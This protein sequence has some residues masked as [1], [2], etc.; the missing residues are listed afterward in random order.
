[1]PKSHRP[2]LASAVSFVVALTLVVA[3]PAARADEGMWTFNHFPAER[4]AQEY[5]FTPSQEWLDHVRLS[6]VRFNSGGSG[7]FL[8][9]D[10]LSITN[11]H[12][13]ADCIHKLSSAE[14]DYMRDGF[15][16]HSLAE[17]QACPDLELNV[18]MSIE[19]VTARVQAAVAGAADAATAGDARRA[20]MAK[21]EKECEDATKLRCDVVTL[22]AGAEF[23]LYRY[24]KYTDVRL[25]F[26][27]AAQLA[28]FG[29]DPDN[30]NYPRYAVDFALFRVWEDGHPAPTPEHLTFKEAGPRE[31]E[32]TFVS[33]NP[34]RTGRLDSVAQLEWLR[35]V[36]YPSYLAHLDQIHG[37]LLAFAGRGAEQ[38]RIAQDDVLGVENSLKALSGYLSGLL[39]PD[40]MDKK[41]R[42]EGELRARVG[43]DPNLVAG[44]PWSD[45][46][47]AIATER[48][49]Y[50]RQAALRGLNS[51]SLPRIADT[52]VWLV[53]ERQKPNAERLREYRETAIPRVLR[54]LYSEAPIY[55]EYEEFRLA[56]ALR[57]FRFQFGLVH[58]LVV[59]VFG[60]RTP[61]QLAHE[62]I[63]GTHLA[64][65]AARKALVEGGS[66]AV[67]AS[68][69]PLIRLARAL[70]PEGRKLRKIEDDE[71]DAVEERAGS[72]IADAYFAVH[73]KDT[74]P[75]A[76]FTLR[77]T[78]GRVTGYEE[79]GHAVSWHTD[80]AGYF[81]RSAQHGGAEPYELPPA[82]V[83]AKDRLDLSDPVD[84]VSTHD[85]IGGNSG[86]P[87]IDREGNF[88]GII[89]DG[90][91]YGLPNN[92][93]YT[94]KQA[95]SIS[96]DAKAILDALT[97][98]YP[99]A[100]YLADELKAGKRGG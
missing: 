96:V 100:S 3:T 95:R 28:Y 26:S 36:A 6:S 41:R 16:A 32:V 91:L 10:G 4:F 51:I 62:L 33:G 31:G 27:P 8:S 1:M 49:I 77:L 17:E 45:I 35:D 15:I 30:F 48:T 65:V 7:S 80:F 60:D 93:V 47:R 63:A 57:A 21:I 55:P 72:R 23:D 78:Y 71:V 73:G 70:E 61:E 44:D 76:T 29:G 75:D 58:P 64:D 59:Q 5:G 81:A 38:A 68:D 18:L 97:V 85:I 94:D 52:I 84:I 34:G 37:E 50:P 54:R 86:S 82:L 39:D 24:K 90:N 92:F 56:E 40:L 2:S 12:V 69:D 20:E 43:Q 42:E 14:H 46:E 53:A 99:E 9:A 22:Y 19:P 66:E 67:A 98:I 25:V 79:A 87:M 74:Y 13:G 11:L 89:F 83:A 88:V